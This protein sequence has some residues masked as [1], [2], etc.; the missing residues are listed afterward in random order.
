M[1]L[2][3]LADF[4]PIW[5]LRKSSWYRWIQ[6]NL[7]ITV[8]ISFK[9]TKFKI[10]VKLLRDI[11]WIVRSLGL[12]TNI[13]S[14]FVRDTLLN[15]F[16]KLHPNVFWDVG[17]NIGFYSW[18]ALAVNGQSEVIL[19][20]ADQTNYELN[21]KTIHRNR[22]ERAKAINAAVSDTN[23]VIEFLVDPV[24]GATGCISSVSSPNSPHSLH[25]EY[26]LKKVIS[27]K[28]I[29]LDSLID[30]G[31][32]PPQL[33]KIDVEGAEHLV[34]AGCKNLLLKYMPIIVM[35]TSQSEIISWLKSINYEITQ[36]DNNN[37]LCLPNNTS[38][39]ASVLVSS[40]DARN[41]L[42]EIK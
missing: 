34:I 16:S 1:T 37:I 18:S 25:Y 26:Q 42:F 29:T 2:S 11:S 38:V 13:E 31:Y 14:D 28:A 23:G 32:S 8:Y 5:K 39:D 10:A 15:I 22:L 35:E 40:Y 6:S 41:F 19:I 33:I 4:R 3:G 17:S 12:K 30:Q 27:V 36:I 24:S 9:H 20:D 7:D 21:V